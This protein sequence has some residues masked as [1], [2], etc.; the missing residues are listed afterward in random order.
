MHFIL[1]DTFEISFFKTVMCLILVALA[2]TSSFASGSYKVYYKCPIVQSTQSVCG[3]WSRTNCSGQTTTSKTCQVIKQI[4]SSGS[5]SCSYTT[6]ST[7]QVACNPLPIEKSCSLGIVNCPAYPTLTLE[8]LNTKYLGA[9]GSAARTNELSCIQAGQTARNECRLQAPQVVTFSINSQIQSATLL[10]R[11][12]PPAE[13]SNTIVP[14]PPPP[15]G[16]ACIFRTTDAGDIRIVNGG[17]ITAKTM[18]YSTKINNP[19]KIETRTCKNG[20][21]TGSYAQLYCDLN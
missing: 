19:C 2:V 10:Q 14:P 8:D 21:L 1:S 12:Q 20:I 6:W 16:G 4:Y 17:S 18:I 11:F 13:I 7:S 9:T 5:T 3:E 15:D